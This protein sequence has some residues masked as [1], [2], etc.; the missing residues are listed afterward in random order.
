MALDFDEM[1]NYKMEADTVVFHLSKSS[2]LKFHIERF[3]S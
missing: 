1:Q 2:I 3:I